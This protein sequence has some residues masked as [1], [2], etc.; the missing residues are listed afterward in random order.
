MLHA[1]S[2]YTY[3]YYYYYYFFYYYSRFVKHTVVFNK[4]SAGQYKREIET[5]QGQKTVTGN[6]ESQTLSTRKVPKE[7]RGMQL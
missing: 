6:W 4:Q 5:I 3:Y 1:V 7:G 2:P